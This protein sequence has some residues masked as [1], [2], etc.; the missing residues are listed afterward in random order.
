MEKPSEI[1]KVS[2]YGTRGGRMEYIASIHWMPYLALAVTLTAFA[3]LKL[4]YKKLGWTPVILIAL[5]LGAG[6]GILFRSDDNAWL[7]WVD[8]IGSAYY[9]YSTSLVV[10]AGK[11]LGKDTSAY[12][13]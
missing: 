12:E 9:A 3:V 4:L 10:K 13:A 8:F 11:L 2:I 6:I 7:R 5:V 1:P